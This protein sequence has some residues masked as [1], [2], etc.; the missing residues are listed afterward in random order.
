MRME[1]SERKI[2]QKV[3]ANRAATRNANKQAML[4]QPRNNNNNALLIL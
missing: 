2:F 4:K 3:E 1:A